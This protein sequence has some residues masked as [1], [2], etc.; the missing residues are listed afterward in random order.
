MYSKLFIRLRFITGIL[1]MIL[2]AGIWI[3][4]LFINRESGTD[5]IWALPLLLIGAFI[6]HGW[7]KETQVIQTTESRKWKFILSTLLIN[8]LILYFIYIISDIIFQAAIDLLSVPGIL[9]PVLLGIFITGFILSWGY[10][11]YSGIFFL[12]WYVLILFAQFRYSEILQRG[13][14]ILI[15]ITIFVHGIL[16]IYYHY[17]IKSR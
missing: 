2:N 11:F 8:Y 17:R 6:L 15:G 4:G 10:E 5:I 16:Y 13:P 9:L 3:N 12:L 7:Y 14:Y 1:L